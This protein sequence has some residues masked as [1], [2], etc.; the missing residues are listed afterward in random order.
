[1]FNEMQLSLSVADSITA[2]VCMYSIYYKKSSYN[3]ET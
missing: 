1:M 3:G 2:Y